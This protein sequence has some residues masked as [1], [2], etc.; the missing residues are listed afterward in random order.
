M[1]DLARQRSVRASRNPGDTWA[2]CTDI[3]ASAS[4]EGVHQCAELGILELF[5]GA[6]SRV[7]KNSRE[8]SPISVWDCRH[9]IGELYDS[10]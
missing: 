5:D 8:G 4:A 6:D 7:G 9:R 2:T 1:A 10:A 3:S